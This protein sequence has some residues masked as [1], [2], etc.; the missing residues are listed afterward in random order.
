MSEK[1]IIFTGESARLILAGKKTQTRRVV[2]GQN[3]D[4]QQVA[5]AINPDIRAVNK[6]GMEY[7]LRGNGLYAIFLDYETEQ[8]EYVKSKHKVGDTIYVKEAVAPLGSYPDCQNEQTVAYAYRADGER[9]GTRWHSPMLMPRNAARI[10]LRIKEV[11]CER[12]QGISAKDIKAEGVETGDQEAFAKLWDGING[13]RGEGAYK[14]DEDPW[15]WVYTFERI[16]NGKGGE[17]K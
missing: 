16:P 3:D 8:Y 9:D 12:L 2:E 1:G 13:K 7:P 15:V 10:F 14:W 11:R 17:A 5:L 4:W 6:D